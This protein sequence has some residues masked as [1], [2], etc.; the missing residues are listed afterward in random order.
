MDDNAPKRTPLYDVYAG[1]DGVKLID[2]GGWEMPVQFRPG[3]IAEH[4]AVRENA[5]LFDVS[6]MGEF[7]IEGPRGEEFL[8]R[9][10]TN[11][12]GSLE[13]GQAQYNLMCYPHGGTVDDLI[14]Y[15][16]E[17]DR[18]LL[19]VNAG[20]IEKDFLWISRENEWIRE[21]PGTVRI[22]DVS[23]DYA[24]LAFQGPK[25]ESY[26]RML[27]DID[28]SSIGSFR[29]RTGVRI[30]GVRTMISRTGY[31]GE[32]GFEIFCRSGD[33]ADLWNAILGVAA[34]H[35]AIPC[36]LGARDT[37]RL[38]ARLPLYGHELSESISPLEAGL[39]IFVDFTK[40]DFCGRDAMI[41]MKE[42][43]I[44]RTLRGCEMQDP[45]VPRQGY[46]VFAGDRAIGTVTSGAKSPTLGSF[47][48]LLLVERGAVKNGDTVEIEINGRRRRGTIVKTPFYK[49]A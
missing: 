17:T 39:S 36:G 12:I 44:P 13:D 28:L 30:G 24:L 10:L 22:E 2:F 8:S 18:Y 46:P 4:H 11:S 1:Y 42:A 9:L 40:E 16:L 5:G 20:N 37:L 33:A 43:G 6:H 49:H 25:A 29:F 41:R 15:R 21:N 48:A 34:P 26:L 38:E 27:T 19:V 45:G 23:S 35:G 14:V 31:T 47:I 7:S 3:I 32:E